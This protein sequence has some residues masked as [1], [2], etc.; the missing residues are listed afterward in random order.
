MRPFVVSILLPLLVWLASGCDRPEVVHASLSD[1]VVQVDTL[2]SN[3]QQL[4]VNTAHSTI[5]WSGS[6]MM[7]THH[8]TINIAIG[9]L[10]LQNN[11]LKGGDFIVI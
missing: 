8:G 6:K 3:Y 10:L 5:R 2:P 11:E 4:Y 1:Q 9:K 7:A